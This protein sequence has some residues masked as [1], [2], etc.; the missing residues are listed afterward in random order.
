MR[1]EKIIFQTGNQ[2]RCFWLNHILNFA[3]DRLALAIQAANTTADQSNKIGKKQGPKQGTDSCQKY[4]GN[5]P[6]D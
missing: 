2:W 6:E 4:F 1:Q 3:S 5:Q